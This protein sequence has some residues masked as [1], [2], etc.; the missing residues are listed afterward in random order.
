[1][2]NFLRK[3]FASLLYGKGKARFAKGLYEGD[4]VNGNM[5]GKVYEGSFVNGNK[6]LEKLIKPLVKKATKLTLKKQE[7]IPENSHL[8]SHFGGQPYF[9]KGEE[10]PTSESGGKM[11]FLF[12]IFNTGNIN[13]PE[14][15]KLLQFYYDFHEYDWLVKIYENINKDNIEIIKKP[16]I[17][18]TEDHDKVLYCEIKCEPINSLPDYEGLEIVDTN[19]LNLV[20]MLDD[21]EPSVDHYG[22][23][24][25]KLV[26]EQDDFGNS[27]L[28]GYPQ[29]IQGDDSPKDKDFQFLFQIASEDE[30]GV[31]WGDCG[32]I[33]VFYNPKNGKTEFTEQCH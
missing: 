24:V 33:Y 2:I 13:L 30:A 32:R 18:K 3:C 16:D 4:W 20:S 19:M 11:E 6:D 25:E 22:E 29:W 23:V 7:K 10:W 26:G 8:E 9:E 17:E 28:G 5:H 12:Q 31:M 15:I 21:E 14:N 27:Q 1:M